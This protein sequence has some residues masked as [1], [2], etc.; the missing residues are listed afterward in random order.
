M[1]GQHK[2]LPRHMGSGLQAVR[3]AVSRRFSEA[4]F[5]YTCEQWR[6]IRHLEE[7]SGLTQ[8]ELQEKVGK[9]QSATSKVLLRL[10]EQGIL[11]IRPSS[12]D[13]RCRK[14]FLTEQGRT[15]LRQLDVL[16][17]EVLQNAMKDISV[18]DLERSIDVISRLRTN[19]HQTYQIPLL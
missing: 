6:T 19:L 3:C 11:E 2:L 8:R 10:R 14:I 1:R 15:I 17:D 5:E 12:K 7:H 9:S 13:R 16:A 18:E 4:G